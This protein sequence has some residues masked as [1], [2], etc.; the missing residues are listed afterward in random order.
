MISDHTQYKMVTT[1]L[2]LRIYTTRRERTLSMCSFKK[3]MASSSASLY[4]KRNA[5]RL[6]EVSPSA[7]MKRSISSGPS[8]SSYRRNK[9]EIKSKERAKISQKRGRLVKYWAPAKN[10]NR[11]VNNNQQHGTRNTLYDDPSMIG[12]TA[13][14]E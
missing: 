8:G 14:H 13:S 3:S 7:A 4:K 10:K 11:D 5:L 12:P 6:A 2:W 1:L 9:R